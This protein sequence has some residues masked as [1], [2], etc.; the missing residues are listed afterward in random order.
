MT[1]LTPL[2]IGCWKREKAV[3]IGTRFAYASYTLLFSTF[4]AASLLGALRVATTAQ[5][6]R[7]PYSRDCIHNL[8]H[9]ADECRRKILAERMTL[10]FWSQGMLAWCRDNWNTFSI[11]KYNWDWFFWA[12]TKW[13]SLWCTNACSLLYYMVA[14]GKNP[15]NVILGIIIII[16]SNIHMTEH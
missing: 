16:N 2:W 6:Y 11:S 5:V 7:A 4:A 8:I 12:S 15:I 14:V 13:G 1:S 10:S 9:C 3:W